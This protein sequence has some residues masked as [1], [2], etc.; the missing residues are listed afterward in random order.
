MPKIYE[1]SFKNM[2]CELIL[3]QHQSTLRTAEEFNVPIKTLEKWITAYNKDNHVF[4]PDYLSPEQKIAKLKREL[5]EKDQT[6]AILKKTISYL[7]KKE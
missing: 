3:K 1:N 5:K 2:I 4:D 7:A 6:I